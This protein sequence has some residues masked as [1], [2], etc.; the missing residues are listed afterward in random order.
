[1]KCKDCPNFSGIQCHGHGD[2]WGTCHLY[3]S[4]T[5][6]IVKNNNAWYVTHKN[7]PYLYEDSECY[8]EKLLIDEI[9][10]KK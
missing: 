4:I 1:M 10:Y 6:F 3:N 5:K 7:I 9:H 2:F 8:F